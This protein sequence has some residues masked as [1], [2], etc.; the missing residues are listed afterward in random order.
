MPKR[1][2]R[3]MLKMMN[4]EQALKQFRE[5]GVVKFGSPLHEVMHEL[6]QD[7]L[8]TLAKLNNSYHTP[9]E[10]REIFSELIGKEVD[11]SFRIFPPFYT[12]CGK[13]I[14]IG[15]NVFINFQCHFQDQGG[16]YIDD[17]SFIGSQVVIATI[18]HGIN[19]KERGD[20]YFASVHIKKG[21]WIGSHVTI[22]PGVTIGENA[23]VAAG[24]VVNRD[25][26]DNTVVGGVP[27]KEISSF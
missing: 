21:A 26:A 1:Q 23:V 15:K 10:I 9:E 8:K 3:D 20:N 7:A 22:L 19:P 11:E 6:A 18:N 5:G 12:E 16:I 2:K 27:A 25:V 4:T 13:N 17:G 24:A 14:F